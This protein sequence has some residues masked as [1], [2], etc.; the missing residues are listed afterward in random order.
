MDVSSGVTGPRWLF[1][2]G[3]L[4]PSDVREAVREGWQDDAVRGRL[5]D[6]GPYPALIDWEDSTAGWVEGHV[7]SVEPIELIEVFDPYEGVG[8]GQFRRV[9]L[10][11]LRG[12]EAWVYVFPHPVPA[13]ALGPLTRWEGPRINLS[14]IDGR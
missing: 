7:R 12:R 5:Y 3:T 13:W 8:D 6:L 9:T 2:Y 11:T 10:R 4:G 1:A 14:R